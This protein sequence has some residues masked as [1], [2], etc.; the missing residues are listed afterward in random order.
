MKKILSSLLAST[1]CLGA[2]LPAFAGPNPAG[3]ASGS[4]VNSGARIV[5]LYTTTSGKTQKYSISLDAATTSQLNTNLVA[6]RSGDFGLAMKTV[7]NLLFPSTIP[8]TGTTTVS[9]NI[10]NL[11]NAI[12]LYNRTISSESFLSRGLTQAQIA[13]LRQMSDIIRKIRA[14]VD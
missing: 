6:F 3:G 5:F 1:L 12:K 13:Q 8:L 14:E 7:A 4:T 9:V 10:N 11:G 2:A